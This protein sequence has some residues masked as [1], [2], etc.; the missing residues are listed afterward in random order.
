MRLAWGDAEFDRAVANYV[1]AQSPALAALG[2]LKPF[3][4]AG[5][6]DDDDNLVGGLVMTEYRFFDAELSI[7]MDPKRIIGLHTMREL[8]AWC[9][10][11]VGLARLTAKVNVDNE[12]ARTFVLKLG[13]HHE[14]TVRLGFDGIH[15]AAL[16]GMTRHDC[17][18]LADRR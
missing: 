2:Q 17:Y 11:D 6:V 1:L 5:F 18:W 12:R 14:G 16:Y 13:F 10:E 9:F 7:F 8:F 15:D 4:S 3:R